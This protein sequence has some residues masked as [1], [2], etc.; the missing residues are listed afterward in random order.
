[1]FILNVIFLH[2]QE[3]IKTW[4]LFNLRTFIILKGTVKEK[5]RGY[6]LKANHFS[7]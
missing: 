6:R 5:E 1:M 4:F 3:T 2:S 7:S